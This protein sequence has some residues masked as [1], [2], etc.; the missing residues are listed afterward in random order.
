MIIYNSPLWM[1]KSL[2]F[3][4]ILL[5]LKSYIDYLIVKHIPKYSRIGSFLVI[6][7]LVGSTITNLQML[8]VICGGIFFENR[9]KV[10]SKKV[11]LHGGYVI[12]AVPILLSI[13]FYFFRNYDCLSLPRFYYLLG[14]FSACSI[15]YFVSNFSKLQHFLCLN[16]GQFKSEVQMTF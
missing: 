12:S 2:F 13:Y 11:C 14:F 15:F 7:L 1:I 9:N 4:N 16:F 8:S 3:G 6:I 5:Y 10:C